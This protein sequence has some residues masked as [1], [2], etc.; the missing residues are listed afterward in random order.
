MQS[1]LN[2]YELDGS[3]PD[4][5]KESSKDCSPSPPLSHS[6]D[7]DAGRAVRYSLFTMLNEGLTLRRNME[8]SVPQTIHPSTVLSGTQAGR[9]VGMALDI[10]P[11]SLA[12]EVCGSIELLR[13]NALISGVCSLMTDSAELLWP[14][15]ERHDISLSLFLFL[16]P[17][18][19]PSSI[20][21]VPGMSPIT[22][23]LLVVS[24]K[25]R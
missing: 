15:K 3:T 22:I 4:W 7:S 23:S 12:R 24:S 5:V 8:K 9:T 1:T 16:N 19:F 11:S 2:R 6:C 25:E 14:I 17:V 13:L 10:I 21:G 18:A 20:T